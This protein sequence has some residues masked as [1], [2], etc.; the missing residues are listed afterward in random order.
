MLHAWWG[1]S[2]VQDKVR[3]ERPIATS[4]RMGYLS[5]NN[6]DYEELVRGLK[7]LSAINGY[8]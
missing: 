7:K 2:Q 5:P 3:I 8:A 6:C 1:F 4:V